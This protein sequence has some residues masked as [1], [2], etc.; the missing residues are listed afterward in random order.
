MLARA[1]RP[2][3]HGAAGHRAPTLG[4]GARAA[5]P[6][7]QAAA[8]PVA[9]WRGCDHGRPTMARAMGGP[10]VRSS[11]DSSGPTGAAQRGRVHWP[12]ASRPAS[13]STPPPPGS[14]PG[15]PGPWRFD[16]AVAECGGDPDCALACWRKH[17]QA[18]GLQNKAPARAAARRPAPLKQGRPLTPS[19]SDKV[20]AF[21][22]KNQSGDLE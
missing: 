1:A 20:R 6:P 11:A 16:D 5:R 13:S 2:W 3:A 21:K 15:S 22:K 12:A 8:P 14:P 18:L 9:R 4:G 17:E 19:F 10:A 7:G